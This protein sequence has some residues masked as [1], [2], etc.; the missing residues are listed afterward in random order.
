MNKAKHAA[1]PEETPDIVPDHPLTGKEAEE[2]Y[3]KQLALL[4][5]QNKER[6]EKIRKWESSNSPTHKTDRR[7]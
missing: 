6:I 1:D 7:T 4:E 5:E 2:D 3:W